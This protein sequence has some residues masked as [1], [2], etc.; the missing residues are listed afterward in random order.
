MDEKFGRVKSIEKFGRVKSIE[1]FG[2]VKSIEKFCG[3][4]WKFLEGNFILFYL[5]NGAFFDPMASAFLQVWNTTT[6]EF[7]RTLLGHKRGIAC[8]QYKD[9]LIAS[10]SSDNTIRYACF[11]SVSWIYRVHWSHFALIAHFKA[12]TY[13]FF[14]SVF[15]FYYT[16]CGTLKAASACESSRA[17]RNWSVVS[18][19]TTNASS[20]VHMTGNEFFFRYK[21]SHDIFIRRFRFCFAE[22]LKFGTFKPRLTPAPL[23]PLFVSRLS[24]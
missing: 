23:S 12:H 10:G 19:L 8:L 16:D 14:S 11:V 9:H 4:D 18:A 20:V 5:L 3:V 1:K 24:L 6:C 21:V 7:V 15:F 22:K 2:G 17:T 13:F